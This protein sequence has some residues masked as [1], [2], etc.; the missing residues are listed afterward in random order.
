MP[1]VV[2]VDEIHTPEYEKA[3]LHVEEEQDPEKL[4][5]DVK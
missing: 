4:V 5:E 2:D 1:I 3:T